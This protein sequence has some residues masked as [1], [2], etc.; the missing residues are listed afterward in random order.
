MA[1]GR[2]PPAVAVSRYVGVPVAFTT[3]RVLDPT[4]GGVVWE[5]PCQGRVSEVT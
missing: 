3:A 4:G 1:D 5:N 2:V